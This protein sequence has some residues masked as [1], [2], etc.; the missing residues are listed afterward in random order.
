MNKKKHI[1]TM[2]GIMIIIAGGMFYGGMQYGTSKATSAAAQSKQG[3][4]RGNG[5][6]NGAMDSGGPA[7]QQR[8][9]RGPNGAAGGGF[10]S[11]QIISKDDTSITVKMRDG[12]SRIIYYSGSTSIGKTATGT[13]TDLSVGQDVMVNGSSS[14]DG[15]IAADNIQIRPAQPAGQNQGQN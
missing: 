6:S 14:A 7:G 4:G 8:G 5:G 3:Q 1:I 9:Q 13:A 15:S 11:G 12:G 2:V 10:S